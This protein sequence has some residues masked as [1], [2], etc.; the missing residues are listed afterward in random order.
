LNVQDIVDKI[1]EIIQ[2]VSA[3]RHSVNLQTEIKYP[4]VPLYWNYRP[5]IYEGEITPPIEEISIE[6]IEHVK[7]KDD[8]VEIVGEYIIRSLDESMSISDEQ[9]VEIPQQSEQTEAVSLS[10]EV[11][12]EV[13]EPYELVFTE[14]WTTGEPPAMNKVY[15][16][17]WSS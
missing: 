11:T 6:I 10:D 2:K 16:E 4:S 1:N 13:T 17:E 9:I 3:Y 15:T 7:L 5:E 8:G 12:V 14:K